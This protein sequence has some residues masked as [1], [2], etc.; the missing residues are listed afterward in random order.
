MRIQLD[1]NYPSPNNQQRR[2]AAARAEGRIDPSASWS[3]IATVAFP[4]N[5]IV[6]DDP[7]PGNWEFRLYVIDEAGDESDPVLATADPIVFE[8]PSPANAFTATVI[9]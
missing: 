7:T 4:Q 8:R 5:R 6:I 2:L 1:W 9:P 3:E